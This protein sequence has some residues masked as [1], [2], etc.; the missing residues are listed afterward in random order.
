MNL[1][2]EFKKIKTFVFD[3]DGVLTDGTVLLL[4]DG[5]QARQ[6]HIKDGLALQI[7]MKNGYDVV[8]VSGGY[9]EPVLKR[10]QYLG[11]T[12][13]YLAVKN[14]VRFLE[15]HFLEQGIKWET[16]L[17]MGDDLPDISVLQ[18]AGI[19]CC[20]ADAV[21]EVKKICTYISPIRGGYGCVRD[22]LEKVLKGNDHWIYDAEVVSK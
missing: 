16:S 21:P 22:V 14:K 18:K 20:P 19:S 15:K 10:L 9:S 13:I 11:V 3:V 6:M 7:A 17:Y 2:K 1:L 4:P 5:V 12:E 8:I